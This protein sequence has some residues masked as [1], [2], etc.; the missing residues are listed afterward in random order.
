MN[1]IKRNKG[2]LLICS[3]FAAVA[4]LL[5]KSGQLSKLAVNLGITS[6]QSVTGGISRGGTPLQVIPLTTVNRDQ[7][8]VGNLS[9]QVIPIDTAL[10]PIV[11]DA[12]TFQAA[13]GAANT[14]TAGIVSTPKGLD[15]L[16]AKA[17]LVKTRVL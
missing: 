13:A 17:E 14:G 12:H 7:F 2:L 10:R 4:Y 16:R 9:T 3:A 11:D 6:G 8:A 1:F 15:A 5:W